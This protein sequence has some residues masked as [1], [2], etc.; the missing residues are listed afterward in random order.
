MALIKLIKDIKTADV[1]RGG[2]GVG[3]DLITIALNAT[4]ISDTGLANLAENTPNLTTIGLSRTAVSDEGTY[5]AAVGL[6][7]C[8]AL[9]T[10]GLAS[11]P[12]WSSGLAA[13]GYHCPCLAAIGLQNCHE[14]RLVTGHLARHRATALHRTTLRLSD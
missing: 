8:P 5:I 14:V 12:S 3:P 7:N 9:T 4:S 10:T 2:S 13:L 6:R 11:H 1:R